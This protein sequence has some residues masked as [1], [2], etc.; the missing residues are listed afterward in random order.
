MCVCVWLCV[1]LL[2][3]ERFQ[4]SVV[5]YST[6]LLE[7]KQAPEGGEE[8]EGGGGVLYV[9]AR[10]AVYALPASNISA[11]PPRTVRCSLHTQTPTTQPRAI[12]ES[13]LIAKHLTSQFL[14]WCIFIKQ[15]DV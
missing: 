13:V 1:G 5:N 15:I 7:E 12:N 3:C 11:S 4:G 8:S 9:G 10:G 14:H 2:G 6:L